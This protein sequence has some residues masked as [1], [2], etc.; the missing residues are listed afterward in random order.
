MVFW[1]PTTEPQHP[2]PVCLRVE[3]TALLSSVLSQKP[4]STFSPPIHLSLQLLPITAVHNIYW[5]WSRS[6]RWMQMIDVVLL[7]RGKYPLFF[8][9]HSTRGSDVPSSLSGSEHGCRQEP[10]SHLEGEKRSVLHT[11]SW[12]ASQ[13]CRSALYV[14]L[15][16]RYTHLIHRW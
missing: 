2:P 14:R 4:S 7:L 8:F 13:H 1:Q 3:R 16:W 15:S 10:L 6:S 11:Q 5:A 12:L 9:F